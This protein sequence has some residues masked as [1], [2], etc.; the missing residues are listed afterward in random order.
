MRPSSANANREGRHDFLGFAKKV[1]IKISRLHGGR[2]YPYNSVLSSEDTQGI[3]KI[4]FYLA[5]RAPCRHSR[6]RRPFC[7]SVHLDT[8]LTT[9]IETRI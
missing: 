5:G 3:S 2:R 6:S 1:L 8:Q 4:R 9:N 7:P